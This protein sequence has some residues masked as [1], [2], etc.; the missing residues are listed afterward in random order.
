MAEDG[1][2]APGLSQVAVEAVALVL[3]QHHDADDPGIDEIGQNE[4]DQPVAPTERNRRLG[5]IAGQGCQTLPRTTGENHRHESGT[6]CHG[7]QHS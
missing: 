5:P 3:G 1:R 6:R 4:V 7:P 2:Q